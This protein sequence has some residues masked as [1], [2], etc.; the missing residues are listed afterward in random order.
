MI[1]NPERVKAECLRSF[2]ESEEVC[3]ARGLAS[4]GAFDG[5]QVDANFERAPG[6]RCHIHPGLEG[7]CELLVSIHADPPSLPSAQLSLA[8]PQRSPA[9][10]VF[11]ITKR[12]GEPSNE[13]I[14]T[15]WDD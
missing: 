1:R 3:P 4:H 14:Y 6:P 10:S 12:A 8:S 13:T 9:A 2:G 11:R 7:P 15:H 5:R